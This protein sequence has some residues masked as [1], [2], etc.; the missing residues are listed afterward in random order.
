MSTS[1]SSFDL[2]AHGLA[3]KSSPTVFPRA[4]STSTRS[5]TKRTPASRRTA[6]LWPIPAQEPDVRR[7]T[8][9]SSSTPPRRRTSGG[10]PVNIPMRS[11]RPSRSIAS[12]RIDYLNTRE[13]LYCF[14]GFAGWDPKY[15][16]QGPRDLLAALSRAV[17]CT[18]C[19]SGRRGRNA[20]SFGD[21]GRFRDLQCR[22]IPREPPTPR[23]G[24]NHQHRPFD[25]E[26]GLVILGTEYAGRD[27][28]GRLYRGE[29][30]RRRKRG[31]LSM[32]CSAHG[33]QAERRVLAALRP[34][35]AP[36][37]RRF[38]PIPSAI[39]SA[40]TS[41]AGA[42]TAS[43]TSKAAAMPRRSI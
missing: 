6:R 43:S 21:A 2:T 16:H 31:V 28:E 40:T 12:G 1:T 18:R 30:F 8:S 7:R 36:A 32:H 38:R 9:A 41:I 35:R 23:D 24:F 13:R 37:R 34:E 42:M 27:E 25:G 26:R 10:D 39:S 29:L 17:S 5:A 11:R 20:A 14:D 22:R 4:R 33:G 15:R 19:S 3:V